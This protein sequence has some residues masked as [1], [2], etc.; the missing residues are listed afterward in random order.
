LSVHLS[1]LLPATREAIIVGDPRRAFA[2]GQALTV[3]PE[4]SHI[5]RGLWG[6]RGETAGGL[7]LTVQ[8]TGVG[9][10]SA[11]AVISDMV[12]HGA[13]QLVRL[14]TCRAEGG[15]PGGENAPLGKVV[16]VSSARCD[17]G[18]SRALSGGALEVQPDPELFNVLRGVAEPAE[19]RSHDLV[20][21]M[22][23]SAQTGGLRDLQ[24]AATFACAARLEVKAAAVL[25]VA[26]DSSGGKIEEP[27]LE[28]A[29]KPLGLAVVE[30]LEASLTLK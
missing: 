24:T 16:L 15:D 26:E 22:D 17:D 25:I 19:V 12:E 11:V 3:Q 1:P 4:M 7:E 14:G 9:G 18:A 27:E 20:S 2:L 10:P 28:A 8:A 5:S 30:A 13:R 21:R 23:S 29:F 6:Y